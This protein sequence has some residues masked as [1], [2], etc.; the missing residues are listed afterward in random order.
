[1]EGIKESTHSGRKDTEMMIEATS[2]VAGV[3]Y[4]ISFVIEKYGFT[5]RFRV[6]VRVKVR[7][8]VRVAISFIMERYG[9]TDRVFRDTL[10]NFYTNSSLTL[11]LTLIQL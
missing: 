8:R 11:T 1:M 5:G 9:F 10:P 3:N 2:S 6:R 7:V 4:T